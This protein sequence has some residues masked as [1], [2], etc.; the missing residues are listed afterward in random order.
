M[1]VN[2]HILGLFGH[3]FLKLPLNW[4]LHLLNKALCLQVICTVSYIS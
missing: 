1:S 2:T 3:I 4:H